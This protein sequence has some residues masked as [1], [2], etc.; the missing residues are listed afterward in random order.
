MKKISEY[1][2]VSADYL[3]GLTD[4]RSQKTD[5]KNI[6]RSTGLDES[7]IKC[8]MMMKT[9]SKSSLSGSAFTG[10]NA[11]SFYSHLISNVDVLEE[12]SFDID[13]LASIQNRGLTESEEEIEH[14]T[15]RLVDGKAH[16]YKKISLR[17]E[18]RLCEEKRIAEGW[19]EQFKGRYADEDIEHLKQEWAGAISKLPDDVFYIIPERARRWYFYSDTPDGVCIDFCEDFAYLFNYP[20]DIRPD[21]KAGIEECRQLLIEDG[22]ELPERNVPAGKTEIT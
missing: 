22:Y 17:E 6:N 2:G 1:F 13:R 20:D 10:H 3:L 4:V 21:W 5:V 11:L 8:L 14:L 19:Y 9:I 7:A 16:Q 15:S 12:I 18:T